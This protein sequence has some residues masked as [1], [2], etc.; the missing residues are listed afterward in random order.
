MA[1]FIDLLWPETT[2]P[3][4]SSSF[5]RS[6]DK[7]TGGVFVLSFFLFLH[8]IVS[9]NPPYLPSSVNLPVHILIIPV[10][11][12]IP[13]IARYLFD[14]EPLAAT[15]FLDEFTEPSEMS[16]EL[17]SV[18]TSFELSCGSYAIRLMNGFLG[19]RCKWIVRW[20]TCR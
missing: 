2:T 8:S 15:I 3:V 20:Y 19:F 6:D 14:S 18:L 5:Y 12:S 9:L 13:T 16:F 7:A 4:P 11:G 10:P 1:D 17:Y